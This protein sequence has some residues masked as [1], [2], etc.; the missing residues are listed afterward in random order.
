MRCMHFFGIIIVYIGFD[1]VASSTL[2]DCCLFIKAPSELVGC[3]RQQSNIERNESHIQ[4]ISFASKDILSYASLTYLINSFYATRRGYSIALLDEVA[5]DYFPEDRRWNKIGAVVEA[6]DPEKGDSKDFEYIV[7]LDADLVIL[8]MSLDIAQIAMQHPTAH[9]ILSSDT[10]D[11]GNTGFMI[12]KKSKWA[13]NFFKIWWESRFSYECDQHAFN[14]LYSSLRGPKMSHRRV[15]ILPARALN[16]AFPVYYT[17]DSKHPVL[18]MVG[19]KNGVR[20]RVFQTAAENFC[21]S[22]SVSPVLGGAADEVI[23]MGTDSARTI[24]R[25]GMSQDLLREVAKN[26]KTS[27]LRELTRECRDTVRLATS[28]PDEQAAV[29]EIEDC[30]QKIHQQTSELRH[31]TLGPSEECADLFYGNYE[32]AVQTGEALPFAQPYLYDFTSKNLYDSFLALPDSLL[33]T[34]RGE[35][36]LLTGY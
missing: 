18:H 11:T 3:V 13:F 12:V 10:S 30:M 32:F 19:E 29:R 7:A 33:A 8:E 17:F 31:L 28:F 1:C 25:Y 9:L 27:E 22:V 35:Q 21:A 5:S 2:F 26:E 36:V 15:A 34:R 16:T 4:L 6:L 24:R 14:D 20:Q 23:T